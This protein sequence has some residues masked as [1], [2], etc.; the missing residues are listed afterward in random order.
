MPAL[1]V[2]RH[3]SSLVVELNRPRAGNSIDDSLLS[4]LEAL[5]C[6]ANAFDSVRVMVLMGSGDK[7]FCAGGDVKFL[8][9]LTLKEL[10]QFTARA[11]NMLLA[12]ERLPV[13]TVAAINGY[14]IGGGLELALACDF[15]LARGSAKMAMPQLRLGIIPG[16]HGIERLQRA[17]GYRRTRDLVLTARSVDGEQARS[18]GLIDGL[19][20]EDAETVHCVDQFLSERAIDDA[21]DPSALLAARAA[22]IGKSTLLPEDESLRVFEDLWAS[23]AHRAAEAKFAERSRR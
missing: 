9:S 20:T 10:S 13:L 5:L 16:W 8:S 23:D 1:H 18:I 3:G 14:A 6:D 12:I 11:R 19:L 22:L 2:R 15:R 21:V 4:E 17:V 7:F